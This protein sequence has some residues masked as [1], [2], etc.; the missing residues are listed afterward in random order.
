MP[1]KTYT[2]DRC[3]VCSLHMISERK[4]FHHATINHGGG[5]QRQGDA[6]R[7]HAAETR[8]GA[9][10]DMSLLT[11]RHTP[12]PQRCEPRYHMQQLRAA[13]RGAW[14]LRYPLTDAQVAVWIRIF[15]SLY[16]APHRSE[17]GRKGGVLNV[18]SRTEIKTTSGLILKHKI[19][20]YSVS[21]NAH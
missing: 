4:Q 20:W 19:W 1:I 16:K 13:E 10:G 2:S 7:K 17:W 12:R 5:R 8:T 6:R 11:C 3:Q 15:T 18:K 14:L 21:A 9:T